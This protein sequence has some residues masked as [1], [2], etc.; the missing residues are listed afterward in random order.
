M[1]LSLEIFWIVSEGISPSFKVVC[2]L[3]KAVWMLILMLILILLTLSRI[4]PSA[5][6]GLPGS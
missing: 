5:K 4:V 3:Q 6:D 2:F 1:L